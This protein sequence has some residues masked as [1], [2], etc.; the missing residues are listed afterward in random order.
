MRKVTER[1]GMQLYY[2]KSLRT[3]F[4]RIL[5]LSYRVGIMKILGRATFR[6]R[7]GCLLQKIS[8]SHSRPCEQDL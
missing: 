3:Y 2:N 6:D 7:W 4:Y 8:A 1:E 5:I